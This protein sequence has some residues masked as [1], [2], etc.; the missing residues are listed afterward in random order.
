MDIRM[1][2]TPKSRSSLSRAVVVAL[3]LAVPLCLPLRPALAE[4]SPPAD[5]AGQEK[6]A[7]REQVEQRLKAA[8]ERMEQAAREMA[9]LTLSL[10]GEHGTVD[11]RVKVIVVKRPML[12]M[13]IEEVSGGGGAGTGVRVMSVSPGGSAEEAGIRANDR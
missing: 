5:G 10:N 11:R 1:N 12:G 2:T 3:L 13:S 8:Q 4:E 6:I 9:E 7:G